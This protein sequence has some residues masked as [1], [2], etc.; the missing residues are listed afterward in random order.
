M[1]TALLRTVIIWP[2]KLTPSANRMG[3]GMFHRG[4]PLTAELVLRA[5]EQPLAME[6]AQSPRSLDQFA[7]G[8]SGIV[9]GLRPGA[10]FGD[11][12][13]AVTRR[14]K[15]LG[16]LPGAPVT[17]IA[18][19]AFHREPVAV[20]VAEGTFALRRHEAA[21]ILVARKNSSG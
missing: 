3:S 13:E 15:E 10:V 12:D 5:V 1:L 9:V 17:V 14:L 7:R 21:K 6:D 19:G 11:L 18:F 2:W 16:F 8:E 4:C 20:K